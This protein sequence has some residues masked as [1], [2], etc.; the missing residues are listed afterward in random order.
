MHANLQ[1]IHQE[2]TNKKTDRGSQAVLF[3]IILADYQELGLPI[4]LTLNSV[5]VA[6]SIKNEFAILEQ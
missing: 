5:P 3:V 4:C 6:A 2:L 1:M